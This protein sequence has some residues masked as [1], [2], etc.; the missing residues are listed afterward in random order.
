MAR[1]RQE[2]RETGGSINV[3][4]VHFFLEGFFMR[5][6]ARSIVLALGAAA[7]LVACGGTTSSPSP[8]NP[9]GQP[10]SVSAQA[11]LSLTPAGGPATFA[12]PSGGGFG[13]NVVFP[14]PLAASNPTI[15]ATI[16]SSAP[17]D[18]TPALGEARAVQSLRQTA[19]L[20]A[21][22]TL[23]YFNLIPSTTIQLSNSPSFSLTVPASDLISGASYFV[24]YYD[25]Q[26]LHAWNLTWEG[27]ATVNGTTLAFASNDLGPF[28]LLANAKYWFALVAVT[29]PAP[30][31]SATPSTAPSASPSASPSTSPSG[32]P[33]A[34]PSAV[35]TATP[36]AVPTATP[37]ATPTAAP[38]ASPTP[39]ASCA[40]GTNCPTVSGYSPTSGTVGTTV[41]ITGTNFIPPL[42]IVFAGNASAAG[43]FT[44]TKI[45]VTVPSGAQTGP[46]VVNTSTGTAS[47]GVFT[48][49]NCTDAG[50][51]PTICNFTPNSGP[52][53]TV[54]TI[55][56][57]NYV[58]GSTVAFTGVAAVVPNS[59][60]A[61]Q[62]QVTVP[63]GAQ[64][65][66]IEVIDPNGGPMVTSTTSF[67]ITQ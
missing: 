59:I 58:A 15:L 32:A 53:G 22:T 45:T 48:V 57:A 56:G 54:V 63:A 2:P 35:P 27:P 3:G 31:P 10:F 40:G 47:T 16:Q 39:P 19:A 38:T 25:A 36:S 20:P 18:G 67:T 11:T 42:S 50:T 66:P 61:N 60:N 65:G 13:G 12:L 21:H 26:T 17:A 43:S 6:H 62:I 23:M 1:D 29:G 37:T 41:V 30:S 24:A 14:A 5:R 33:T 4:F 55:N 51:S 52:A 46:I 28:T 44:S 8:V 49:S 64:T 34:T 7:A 9:V